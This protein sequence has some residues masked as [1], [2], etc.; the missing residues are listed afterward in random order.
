MDKSGKRLGVA[1]LTVVV[2]LALNA[3]AVLSGAA[4]ST[5]AGLFGYQSGRDLVAAR[6]ETAAAEPVSSATECAQ[7]RPKR[8]YPGGLVEV[9]GTPSNALPV[10]R[11]C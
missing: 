4:D 9:A 5:Y 11:M 6:L 1:L 2:V 7:S 10:V 3:F 8:P